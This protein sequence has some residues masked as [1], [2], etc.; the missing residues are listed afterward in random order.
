VNGK[1]I[2]DRGVTAEPNIEPIPTDVIW[3]LLNRVG[4]PESEVRAMSKEEAISRLTLF[5][6][7]G[8]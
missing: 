6:T 4:L 2:P 5:W 7:T 1:Q 3:A 8:K